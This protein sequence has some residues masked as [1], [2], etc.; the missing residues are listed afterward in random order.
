MYLSLADRMRATHIDRF[1]LVRTMR[2]QTIAEHMWCVSVLV[3][4]VATR[5][6]MDPAPLIKVALEHDIEEVITGDIPTPTKER[7]KEKGWDLNSLLDATD[8]TCMLTEEQKL[9]LKVCDLL[10]GV[11]FLRFEGVGQHAKAVEQRL[12][13]TINTLTREFASDALRKVLRSV[14]DDVL[15]EGCTI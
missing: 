15:E 11:R 6:Q 3:K 12:F 7:A 14:I 9:I 10:D 8:I 1:Q 4:E 5:A 2:K 13:G